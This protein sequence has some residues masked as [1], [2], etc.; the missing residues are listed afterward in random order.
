MGTIMSERRGNRG[1]W[2][3]WAG[4]AVLAGVVLGAVVRWNAPGQSA[5]DGTWR[6]YLALNSDYAGWDAAA[7]EDLKAMAA[8]PGTAAQEGKWT[9]DLGRYFAERAVPLPAKVLTALPDW[10]AETKRMAD[11]ALR[12]VFTFQGVTAQVPRL[13]NGG[14]DWN[15][16]GPNHDPEFTWFL[17]RMTML[18][19]LYVAW[20]ETGEEKYRKGLQECGWT[21]W[22]I[23][24]GRGITVCRGRGGRW[25]RRGGCRMRGCRY[26]STR[27][28]GRR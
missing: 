8:G 14:L 20:K 6:D 5:F 16:G 4:V 10:N 18:P 21:G 23:I 13:A 7:R 24:Q 27:A 26:C 11:E 17:N 3:A 28:G 1:R 9:A 19:A 22:S 2:L 12:D 15:W 25:R